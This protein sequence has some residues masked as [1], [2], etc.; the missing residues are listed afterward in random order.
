MKW[1][2]KED[3]PHPAEA[4]KL[5]KPSKQGDRMVRTVPT[6]V[7]PQKKERRVIV[8]AMSPP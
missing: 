6:G 7:A 4:R 2:E 8:V 1:E 5:T 3:G